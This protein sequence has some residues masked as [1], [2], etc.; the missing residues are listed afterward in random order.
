[1]GYD[2]AAAPAPTQYDF[3]KWL[4]HNWARAGLVLAVVL[5]ALAP[6]IERTGNHT[7][8]LVYLWLPIYM[9]HQYEEHSSGKFLAFYQRRMPN[10]APALTERKLLVVNLGAVWLLFLMA[11]YAARFGYLGLAL[12]APYLSVINAVMHVGQLTAWRSYNPG[13]WTAVLL[14]LPGGVYTIYALSSAGATYSSNLLG[15]GL[16]LLAHVLL[17]ALGKGWIATR[18]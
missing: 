12:Y 13:L 4:L 9:L 18:L 15:F 14:F 6:L 5:L 16:G 3:A 7:T 11:I 1:M 10:I 17:F 2:A 8:L